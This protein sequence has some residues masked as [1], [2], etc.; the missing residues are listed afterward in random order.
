LEDLPA[1]QLAR[2]FKYRDLDDGANA[3]AAQGPRPAQR[4][5]S[6]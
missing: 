3:G 1:P 5:I 2:D 6:I 4:R